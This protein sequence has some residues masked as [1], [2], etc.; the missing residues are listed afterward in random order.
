MISIKPLRVSPMHCHISTT[1]VLIAA[2][3]VLA[4]DPQFVTIEEKGGVL[5]ASLTETR[6]KVVDRTVTLSDNGRPVTR[7]I[8]E[9]VPVT[10][11]VNVTLDAAAGDYFDPAGNRIDAKK[12]PDVLKKGAIIAVSR[13]GKP[14]DPEVLKKNKDIVAVLLQKGS[15]T[16]KAPPPEPPLPVAPPK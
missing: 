15:E 4:A 6:K 14:V 12:L 7:T 11:Q 13:D 1:L 2:P 3:A 9:V 8:P 16:P 5:F 10:V